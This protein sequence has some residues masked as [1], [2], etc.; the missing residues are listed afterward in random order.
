MTEMSPNDPVVSVEWLK[1]RLTTS[2][3]NRLLLFDVRFELSAPHAGREAYLR[4]HIP[5]AAYLDLEQDLSG[6]VGAHG[7]RHPLPD[8]DRLAETL[9]R[10]GVSGDSVL[11]FY[12]QGASAYA[13]RTW[14]L[15]T[16]LGHPAAHV[17][18]GGFKAWVESGG[19]VAAGEADERAARSRPRGDFRPV[20]REGWIASRDEVARLSHAIQSGARHTALVDARAPERFRGEIEPIDGVAGHIPGA[21]NR[22]YVRNF[23]AD[24]RWRSPAELRAHYAAF[25]PLD[26]VVV[27][28]GSG[29]SAC[30]DIL[31][32]VR[33]GLPR[34]RLYPGSWSDWI[35][36]PDAPVGRGDEPSHPA[37]RP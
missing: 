36:Y 20:P 18:D 24:G 21:V 9:R 35:S 17:L 23:D 34:P 11:V 27:Y 37:E 5:G 6:P 16:W 28:C 19:A 8:V 31:G 4:G 14:W 7:G 29:V 1:K 15:L 10:Y 22:D 25:E 32:M 2:D 3:G 30:A 12:D 26:D 33:A 13:A